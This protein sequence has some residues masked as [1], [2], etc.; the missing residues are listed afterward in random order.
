MAC[1][2]APARWQFP[3]ETAAATQQH[4][5]V[6][7]GGTAI[8]PRSDVVCVAPRCGASAG[9]CYA[10]VWPAGASW[11][12]DPAAVLLPDGQ[13]VEPGMSVLGGCGYLSSVAHMTGEEANDAATACA[14]PTGEIA[15]FSIGV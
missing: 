14:G 4:E 1:R 5:I 8:Q 7:A 13:I 15:T 2:L 6:E 11:R 3:A 10:I 12:P 9:V